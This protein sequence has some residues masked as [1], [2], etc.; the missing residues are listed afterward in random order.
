MANS[1]ERDRAPRAIRG[2]ARAPVILLC[3]RSWRRRPSVAHGTSLSQFHLSSYALDE[4]RPFSVRV[5][6]RSV[7]K[8][9]ERP[10][11][12]DPWFLELFLCV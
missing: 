10:F 2:M 5:G 9:R 6:V 12:L 8:K 11:W 3:V 7:A 1:S 4:R